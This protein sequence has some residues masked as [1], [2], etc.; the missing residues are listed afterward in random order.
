MANIPKQV[1]LGLAFLL[2]SSAAFAAPENGSITGK[3]ADSSGKPQMGAVVEIFT[4]A[5][6]QPLR[7]FTDVKGQYTVAGLLP[8]TYFVKATATQFLPTIREN[9]TLSAGA[10]IVVNLTLNTLVEAFQLLP[11]RKV[12]DNNEDDWRWTLRSA[13]NRPILRVLG[14]DGPLVVVSN[15]EDGSDRTLKA[16][17]A[18]V[19]GTGGD[20]STG[21]NTKTEV[22]LEQS[23]FG[24]GTITLNGDLG[25]AGS[26]TNGV[27][28]AGYQHKF[29]N[30][31]NPEFAVTARR[32]TTPD[33]ALRHAALNTLALSLSDSFSVADLL[34]FNYGGELQ[35]VQFRGR[36]T[37]FRPFGAVTAHFGPNTLLE[38]RYATSRPT[39]RG[40]KGFDSA[41]ADLSEADPR[42]SLSAGMPQVERAAHHEIAFSRRLGENNLQVALFQDKIV[43]PALSGI[44]DLTGMSAEGSEDVLPDIYSGT[45]TFT[46]STLES[47]GLRVVAQRKLR[48]NLTATFNYSMGGT[49]VA[50]PDQLLASASQSMFRTQKR[51]AV[52]AKFAGSVPKTKTGWIASYKWTNG[53]NAVIPVDPFNASAGMSDPFLNLFVRQPIPNGGFFPGKIEALIDVRNL[54]S[55]GYVPMLGTDGRTVYLV[56]SGRTVRGGLAFNF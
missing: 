14:N 29:S 3:V 13:A 45:F 1:F 31:S 37:A 44:G 5:A 32:F 22:Q 20:G 24:S 51:H 6:T 2:L 38:Y 27:L 48:D 42:V 15:K 46:G 55:Q 17:V 52:T 9:V 49:L 18:F 23:L 4:S 19:A 25:G 8:G 50:Q 36:T 33:T 43:R 47:R 39:T 53:P 10:R 12:S 7:A 56:Q 54:L 35:S 11:A 28:R 21:G 30:G 40:I 16:R 26:F 34:E 41:P